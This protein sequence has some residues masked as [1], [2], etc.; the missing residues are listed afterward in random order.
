MKVK[1]LLFS[2][3]GRVPRQIFW[4]WNAVYYGVI[5]FSLTF[6]SPFIPTMSAYV[7]PVV[8]LVL[9][10]PDLAVTAKRWHDRN[11]S[12][13]WLLLS[14]PLI[15]SRLMMPGQ[16]VDDASMAVGPSTATQLLSFFSLLCGLVILIECGLR[17]GNPLENRYG[18]PYEHEQNHEK[19]PSI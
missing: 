13:K 16:M 18:E 3:E 5:I 8:L 17:K 11:K 19:E 1:W 6:V 12:N 9:L 14:M 2:F 10:I 7:M 15:I 4:I